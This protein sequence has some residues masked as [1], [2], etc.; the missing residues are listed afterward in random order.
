MVLAH[1]LKE[2][3]PLS[4]NKRSCREGIDE[5]MRSI[6]EADPGPVRNGQKR[7]GDSTDD[8]YGSGIHCSLSSQQVRLLKKL[9]QRDITRVEGEETYR[10]CTTNDGD[11]RRVEAFEWRSQEIH[12]DRREHGLR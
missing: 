7:H 6:V 8:G 3:Y 5:S 1:S 9:D 12:G 10:C 2:E 11:G 4:R